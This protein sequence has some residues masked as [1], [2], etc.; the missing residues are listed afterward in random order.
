MINR[1]VV[2]Q[3]TTLFWNCVGLAIVVMAFGMSWSI[4]QTSAFELELAQY[5]LRTGTALT[6]VQKV[7]DTLET[8]AN[9][10]PITAQKK[11][12]IIEQLDQ[13]NEVIEQATSE[14]EN[15]KKLIE[16]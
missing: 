13:S 1:N 5:K 2:G 15:L 16:P 9:Q 4:T 11:E 6:K 3:P 7:S 12:Q 10:L 8:T 14:V